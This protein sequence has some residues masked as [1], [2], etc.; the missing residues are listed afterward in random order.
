[1]MNIPLE[2]CCIFAQDGTAFGIGLFADPEGLNQISHLAG[3]AAFPCSAHGQVTESMNQVDN[4]T[5][6]DAQPP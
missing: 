2:L 1:M 6:F 5:Q 3:S 4:M